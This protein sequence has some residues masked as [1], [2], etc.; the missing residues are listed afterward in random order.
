VLSLATTQFLRVW[1][2]LIAFNFYSSILGQFTAAFFVL[3][4][5]A[6]GAFGLWLAA[7]LWRGAAWAAQAARWGLVAFYVIGWLD[8]IF[9]QA[10]G[11]QTVSWTFQLAVT[12]LLLITIFAALALPQTQAFFGEKNERALKT[13]RTK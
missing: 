1:V 6:W 4:G 9:L 2:G 10:S 13:R 7:G 5:L 11:P 8:Q 12:F 3:S